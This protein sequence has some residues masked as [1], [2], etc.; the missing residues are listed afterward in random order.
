MSI[1]TALK[2]DRDQGTLTI[3]V[4]LSWGH[5]LQNL[6]LLRDL[7]EVQFDHAHSNSTSGNWLVRL[8]LLLCYG[9][10]L[11]C[12]LTSYLLSEV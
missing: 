11:S 3:S 12:G 10:T 5:V 9:S 4:S 8:Y 1:S 2:I 6:V 7:H